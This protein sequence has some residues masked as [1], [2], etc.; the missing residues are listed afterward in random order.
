MQKAF[1]GVGVQVY[2]G[3]PSVRFDEDAVRDLCASRYLAFDPD[4]FTPVPGPAKVLLLPGLWNSGPENWQSY[5][6]RE[7]D[8]CL[9]VIQSDWETPRREDWVA[10]LEKAVAG[11]PEP[12][13]LAAHSLACTLVGHWAG[14]AGATVRKVRGAL[15][16]APSDVEAPSY[17]R[18]RADSSRCLSGRSPSQR[19]WWRAAT[20]L[21]CRCPG[22]GSSCRP[23]ERGFSRRAHSATS[24]PIQGW[25]AGRRARRCS[26]SCWISA[27]TGTGRTAARRAPTPRTPPRPRRRSA[28]DRPE[29]RRVARARRA[30]PAGDPGRR[31]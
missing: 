6:E 9:R 12:V 17:P 3:V 13:V 10:T 19:W 25:E 28:A 14:S 5:W 15:L 1:P 4:T 7:R 24:M 2:A 22:R 16:V 8:D 20:T 18:A 26:A 27:R 21:M 29:P 11:A 23:G 31:W 30:A